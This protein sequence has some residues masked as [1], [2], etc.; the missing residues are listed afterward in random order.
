MKIG[1]VTSFSERCS[2]Q[3]VELAFG[4]RIVAIEF[5]QIEEME[6]LRHARLIG[7]PEQQIERRRLPADIVI[8][9]D[10]VP[11]QI[12]RAQRVERVGHGLRVEHAARP[13]PSCL[14]E[15]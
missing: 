4:Q 13:D 1:I 10:I 8:V 15:T 6:R 5:A 7:V 11:D 12:V 3:Q 14:R 2:P 9:D